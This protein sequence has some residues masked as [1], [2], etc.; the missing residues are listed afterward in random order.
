MM[1]AEY[2]R[3]SVR[4]TPP[5]SPLNDDDNDDASFVCDIMSPTPLM[6]VEIQEL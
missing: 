4:E 2:D 5:Y 6:D 1:L 3:R